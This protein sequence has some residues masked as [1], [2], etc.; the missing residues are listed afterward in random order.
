[1]VQNVQDQEIRIFTINK[2]LKYM[3]GPFG[4]KEKKTEK[5]NLAVS[6]SDVH[7]QPKQDGVVQSQRAF[8]H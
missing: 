8:F 3:T 1:M 5:K 4:T 2:S 6:K 7:V